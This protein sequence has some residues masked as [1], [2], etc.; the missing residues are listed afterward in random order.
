L[1]S[2]KR[3]WYDEFI[4]YVD[5]E[6]ARLYEFMEQ[7]GLLENTWLILTSDHGEMFERGIS[8]HATKVFFEPVIRVPLLVFEPGRKTRQDI[9]TPTQAI[10]LFPTLLHV[11]GQEIPAWCEGGVLPPYI[12]AAP[13][14][15]RSIFA[16]Q[17]R[18]NEKYAPI[19][20]ATAML[21]RWPYKL[22]HYF[23]YEELGDA[24][25]MM[26]LYHLENDPDELDDLSISHKGV[27]SELLDEL[28]TAINKADR[29][30][31]T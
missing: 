2:K 4:L 19:Q 22:V 27:A 11:T 13:G 15:P 18:Y 25:E 21:V 8:G 3:T 17:A 26:E 5:H 28:Q 30:Y 10:D 23:G 16:L 7:S 14:Q 12:P 9:F 6:F 20:E 31:Q 29:L 24:G 1:L